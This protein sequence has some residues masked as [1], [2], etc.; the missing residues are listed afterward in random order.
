[1]ATQTDFWTEADLIYSYTWQ[2]GVQ[3]GMLVEVFKN[4]WPQLTAGMPLL[5]T[6]GVFEAFSLAALHSAACSCSGRSCRRHLGWR[7]PP[8]NRHGCEA[9]RVPPRS[10]VVRADGQRVKGGR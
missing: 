3:D 2:Q 4:R 5:A 8:Q 6:R 1:M 10:D 9:G 7:Y